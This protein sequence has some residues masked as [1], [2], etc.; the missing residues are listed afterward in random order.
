[1]TMHMH[2]LCLLMAQR[3]YEYAHF[4]KDMTLPSKVAA[5][6]IDRKPRDAVFF[7]KL[8]DVSWV[9]EDDC[10]EQK[11]APDWY[12]KLVMDRWRVDEYGARNITFAKLAA[13]GINVLKQKPDADLLAMHRRD[14]SYFGMPVYRFDWP[15]LCGRGYKGIIV[16]EPE[17]DMEPFGTWDV[18]TL[19]VWDASALADVEH[20]RNAGK[21]YEYEVAIGV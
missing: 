12:Q 15:Q 20:F 11:L 3:G 10:E 1:M 8:V 9:C 7:S 17:S 2:D 5:L 18:D 14:Q 13:G 16:T 6:E 4:N 19:A 21:P